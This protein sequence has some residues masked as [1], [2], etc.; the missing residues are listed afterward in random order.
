MPF[1]M[2]AN[3]LLAY[4]NYYGHAE[5]SGW[6]EFDL[7]WLKKFSARIVHGFALLIETFFLCAQK[8][9]ISL[10]REIY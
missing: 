7:T 9:Y 1:H 6:I 8:N 2:A 5:K 10:E 3:K 4:W